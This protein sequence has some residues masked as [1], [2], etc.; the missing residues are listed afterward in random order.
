MPIR[1]DDRLIG[2]RIIRHDSVTS[3]NDV[4]KQ[5][6]RQA[7]AGTVV[8]TGEQTQGRGTRGRIWVSPAGANLL[9]SVVLKPPIPP[10]EISRLSLVAAVGVAE[11]LIRMC[12]LPARTK[13][14]ND[15]RVDGK[16]IA[17]IL[18]ETVPGAA[19]VGIGLNVNWADL[20][21]ELAETATSVYLQLGEEADL[22]DALAGVLD[23]LEIAYRSFLQ[24]GFGAN[25]AKVREL[26]CTAGTEVEV[27]H[28]GN[29]VRGVAE[30]IDADGSLLVRLADGG[31]RPIQA[32]GLIVE[33]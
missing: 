33:R 2:A 17:G 18:I 14:P 1:T 4:A 27:S 9:F 26:D 3:T 10:E 25:L 11:Y 22:G 20:P 28:E 8:W 30:G 6:A 13:W 24:D 16:K 31:V 5:I 19:I 15:V 23:S 12:G 32:A 29:T 7:G 21:P